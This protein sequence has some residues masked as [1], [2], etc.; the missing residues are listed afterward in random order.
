LL[1]S[2]S[3]EL[4]PKSTMKVVPHTFTNVENSLLYQGQH[5]YIL[6]QQEAKPKW[7]TLE[8][9]LNDTDCKLAAINADSD[10]MTDKTKNT[11]KRLEELRGSLSLRMSAIIV[12]AFN[13]YQQMSSP[14]LRVEWDDIVD[15]IY[16][17]TGWLD[18]TGVKS[19]VECGQTWETLAKC[20]RAHLLTVAD[21]DAS[22]RWYTYRTVTIKKPHRLA[23]KPFWNRFRELDDK[24][25]KLPCLKDTEKCPDDV[26]RANVSMTN[27]GMCTL[28]M[29]VVSDEIA[30]EYDFLHDS[31]PTDPKKLVKELTK[32]ENKFKSNKYAT[33]LR[34][35]G[36]V[37]A[38]N[39]ARTPK[40]KRHK[41]N[42]GSGLGLAAPIPRKAPKK[43]PRATGMLCALCDK[44][45]G[46]AKSHTTEDC[47]R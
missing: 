25:P 21:E 11:L 3:I 29:R 19:T 1:K 22:E 13:L 34:N 23:I 16:F 8:L 4:A 2:I 10:E 27:F 20:K 37:G 40:D 35:N 30:D 46:P 43:P 42:R 14:M 15:E 26:T 6:N 36:H 17:S 28:L 39:D 47:K 32:I 45:G 18:D 5:N 31:V 7:N 41:S 44:Y 33:D 24:A 12:K 38:P 9:V